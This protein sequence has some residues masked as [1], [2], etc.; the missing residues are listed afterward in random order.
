MGGC[1]FL[2]SSRNRVKVMFETIAR[3]YTEAGLKF[4]FPVRVAERF[5]PT[6]EGCGTRAKPKNNPLRVYSNLIVPQR[7]GCKIA[8]PGISLT[9]FVS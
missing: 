7:L 6:T 8:S 4:R 1:Y 5:S 2:A 3:F 9:R